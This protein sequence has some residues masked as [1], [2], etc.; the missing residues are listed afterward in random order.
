MLERLSTGDGRLMAAVARRSVPRWID[1]GLRTVTHAGDATI[2][3]GVSLLLLCWPDTRYLGM[4]TSVANLASHL[5]V[6]LLKRT[7]IRQRPSVRLPGLAP[8]VELP[9]Q[10]SFPSGHSAAAMAL[11]VST[12]LQNPLIGAAT[13]AVALGVG[14]SRV[15]L[16]VHYVTDVVVG[17]ALGAA[18][19]VAVHVSLR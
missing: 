2:T 19:A 13:L 11:A 5:A 8:L 10:F 4:L 6:Q 9:D 16:R 14:A 3:V 12:L 17:Q 15:Y 7:V 1:L 18:A